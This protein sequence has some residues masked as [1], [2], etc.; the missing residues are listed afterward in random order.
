MASFP[1]RLNRYR[2]VSLAVLVSAALHAAVMV[3]VPA[4]IST[5]DNEDVAAYSATLDPNAAQLVSD[6]PAAPAPSPRRRP[7]P[8]SSQPK[9]RIAPP[10]LALPDALV[11]VQ[12][13][14]M[15]PLA[16]EP[17]VPVAEEPTAPDKV[18]LA[19]PAVPPKALEPER[20]PVDTFPAKLS[21]DYRLTSAL[22]DGAATYNWTREGD[23]YRVS[24]EAF[25]E[26]FFAVF[27]EGRVIQESRGTVTANGLRPK[28]F[29]ER[30]PGGPLEGLEFDWDG[31]QVTFDR[32]GE[33]KTAPLTDN[34]V[35]WL[36]MI[37]Q[38]AHAPPQGESFD[39]RVYTQRRMYNFKLKVLGEETIEIP[40]GTVRA[41][42]LRH[43]DPE[44]PKEVV[45]VW[46]GM[47]QHYL[48][49]KLR[50][51]V[52]RNRLMVEQVAT[53]VTATEPGK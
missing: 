53:R 37:F 47:D 29:S 39:L 36:S 1:Q 42:H 34:T 52:A 50:F 46:L 2:L 13:T 9:S 33:K 16:P 30:K 48:P 7:G 27:L 14:A 6:Q 17:A 31:K 35:D 28:E 51:P 20:F 43:V 10:P 15:A 41:I 22:A 18:A 4:R 5:N 44:N 19:Q 23:N 40:L 12:P 25:A 11:P 26:G 8:N 3:A 32:N 38:L 49:V 21:I 45:D 24:A